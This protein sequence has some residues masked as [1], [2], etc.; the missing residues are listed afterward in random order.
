M[1]NSGLYLG[2]RVK[3]SRYCRQVLMGCNLDTEFV[4]ALNMYSH[5][6]YHNSTIA[7][8]GANTPNTPQVIVTS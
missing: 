6:G 7:N 3:V 4:V 2:F 8:T 5:L 1:S